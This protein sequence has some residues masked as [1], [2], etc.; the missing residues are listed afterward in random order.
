MTQPPSDDPAEQYE[1]DSIPP[2]RRL[3]AALM[4]LGVA[5]TARGRGAYGW[6]PDSGLPIRYLDELSRGKVSRSTWQRL[7]GAVGGDGQ[8]YLCTPGVFFTVLDVLKAAGI[9]SSI[10]EKIEQCY[11]TDK[12]VKDPT[13]R[14]DRVKDGASAAEITVSMIRGL[15][16]ASER[17]QFN[18]RFARRLTLGERMDLIRALADA[19]A[20]AGSGDDN[21]NGA[22]GANR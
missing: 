19:P 6:V 9:P 11:E 10:I 5:S 13:F 1:W 21:D 8:G 22:E 2:G 17:G 18:A 7:V 15:P 4:D 3:R 14:L 16:D 20:G 12:R